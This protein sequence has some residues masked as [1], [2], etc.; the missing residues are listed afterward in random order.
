[1]WYITNQNDAIPYFDLFCLFGECL[2]E[3]GLDLKIHHE[4]YNHKLNYT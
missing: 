3:K 1:M 2:P 4:K